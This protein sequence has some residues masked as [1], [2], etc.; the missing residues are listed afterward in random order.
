MHQDADRSL[1][2][3]AEADPAPLVDHT[4]LRAEARGG[5]IE[6]LCA[7]AAEFGFASVC[8][9]PRW[10]P[11]AARRLEGSPVRV[12]TVLGFPLGA[13]GRRT[14]V[15]AARAA[16]DEGARELDAV[17]DIGALRDGDDA[18]VARELA[19]LVAAR[20][21]GV[22]LK[23]ILETALLTP[24]ERERG[25][26]LVLASGADF[27]KTSTGFGPGGATLEDVALLRR[28][29]GDRMGVKASGGIRD[30]P[31]LLAMVEAGADRIGTSS[32]VAIVAAARGKERS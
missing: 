11:L 28:V 17:I 16:Q 32:G 24:E 18:A 25:A 6:A 31:T 20:R 3:R 13:D 22:R 29:A 4:L 9:N 26:G 7:E 12:G 5:E 15:E 2:R 1:R 10:V 14:K 8:V 19:A 27:V 23:V 21:R 30:L